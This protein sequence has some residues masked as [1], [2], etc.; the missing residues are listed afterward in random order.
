MARWRDMPA[1]VPERLARFVASEWPGACSH[2]RVEAWK[3]ACADWLAADSTREPRPGADPET[4][5]WYAA[6]GSRRHLPFGDVID[7]LNEAGR[8]S[9]QFPP[10]PDEYRPA[11]YRGPSRAS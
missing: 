8:L 9:R 4:G 5:R 3:Q 11:E 6:G 1:A 2:E 7:L 10:C